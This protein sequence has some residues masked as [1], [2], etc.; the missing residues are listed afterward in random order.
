MLAII[1]MT[2][3]LQVAWYF[4]IIENGNT[5]PR[6]VG[7]FATRDGCDTVMRVYEQFGHQVDSCWIMAV[8]YEYT[9][10]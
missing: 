3:Y 1:A 8:T 10:E 4:P 7:P 9:G 6:L 2:I 5:H